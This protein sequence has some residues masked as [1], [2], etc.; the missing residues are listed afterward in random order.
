[1]E[2][3]M[4]C[5]A[6]FRCQPGERARRPGAE[7]ENHS[8]GLDRLARAGDDSHTPVDQARERDALAQLD[9]E[10]PRFRDQ[11]RHRL[12]AFDE[13]ALGIIGAMAILLCVPGGKS[14]PH[15]GAIDQL[16]PMAAA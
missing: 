4:S 3:G 14:R 16:G 7:S 2:D 5:R 9:A 11:P 12:A 10:A 6:E 1:M 13:A 8:I 15:R